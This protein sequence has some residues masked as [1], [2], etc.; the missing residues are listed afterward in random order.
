LDDNVYYVHSDCDDLASNLLA[1][2]H[3]FNYG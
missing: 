1:T 3:T 2:V